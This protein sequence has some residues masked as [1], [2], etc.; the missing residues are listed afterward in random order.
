M[1]SLLNQ[2]YNK[3]NQDIMCIEV[4]EEM[5]CTCYKASSSGRPTVSHSHSR[6]VNFLSP[7]HPPALQQ[8]AAASKL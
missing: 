2:F 8:Q 6:Y 4:Y 3:Y 7:S 1:E 5:D